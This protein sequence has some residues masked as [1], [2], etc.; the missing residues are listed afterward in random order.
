MRFISNVTTALAAVWLLGTLTG[1][2]DAQTKSCL[3]NCLI[4]NAN[5][6]A[7]GQVKSICR[8]ACN[9]V[10]PQR[11]ACLN[12]ANVLFRGA[13]KACAESLRLINRG[14]P[15]LNVSVGIGRSRDGNVL[16]QILT[17][18][19]KPGCKQRIRSLWT[20]A[21]VG[22]IPRFRFFYPIRFR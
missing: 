17:Y 1:I 4:L 15:P 16:D 8:A 19:Y 3:R 11:Q 7:Q 12:E 18:N 13:S 6:T 21:K 5:Q 2:A 22:T 9:A 14:L 10:R 20:E